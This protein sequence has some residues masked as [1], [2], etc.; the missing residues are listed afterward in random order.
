MEELLDYPL[1]PFVEYDIQPLVNLNAA[2]DRAIPYVEKTSARLS[3]AFSARDESY[4]VWEPL[5]YDELAARAAEKIL[6][7]TRQRLLALQ[8]ES[9]PRLARTGK[10]GLLVAVALSFFEMDAS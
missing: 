10:D 4:L 6:E 7:T 5:T 2:F 1:S 9:L 3:G 8:D